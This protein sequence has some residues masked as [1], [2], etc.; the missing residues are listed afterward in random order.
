MSE[1]RRLEVA[2]A[3]VFRER[4][5]LVTQ[6]RAG[7]HL[8]GSWELPGGKLEPGETPEQCAARELFEETGV[9]VAPRR[10]L[11]TIEWDYPERKVAL[12]PVECEWVEG[13]GDAIEVAA[14]K[15]ATRAELAELTFP[16]ANR[17]LVRELCA[18]DRLD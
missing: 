11:P 2:L 10:R 17:A 14:L 1:A 16:P 13:D 4:R 3:L 6:R 7:G 9:R 5:L 18:S 12:Y 8:G 15:W